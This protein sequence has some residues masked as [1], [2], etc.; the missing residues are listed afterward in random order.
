MKNARKKMLMKS[1]PAVNFN[2]ILLVSFSYKILAQK[3]TELNITREKLLNLLSY[4]KC[5]CKMLDEI[6]TCRNFLRPNEAA[7][8]FSNV[9][10]NSAKEIFL[11]SL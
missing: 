7:A 10:D 6:D 5:G 11:F 4:E 3:V 2:N 8:K 9:A 1:T